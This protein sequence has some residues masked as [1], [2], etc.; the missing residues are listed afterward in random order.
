MVLVDSINTYIYVINESIPNNEKLKRT[1]FSYFSTDGEERKCSHAY[2]KRIFPKLQIGTWIGP[3]SEHDGEVAIQQ[4]ILD[5]AHFVVDCFKVF[6][7]DRCT[8]FDPGITD[9][10]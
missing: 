4:V 2:R 1:E 6:S 5:M 9:K 3:L 10:H 8:H 7:V